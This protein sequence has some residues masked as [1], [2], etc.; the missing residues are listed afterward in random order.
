MG[1]ILPCL[2][3]SLRCCKLVKIPQNEEQ[4]T[5]WS[6]SISQESFVWAQLTLKPQNVKPLATL[7]N[8]GNM[9]YYAY[10]C[11]CHTYDAQEVSNFLLWLHP[12]GG[13]AIWQQPQVGG[14][15]GCGPPV[16]LTGQRNRQGDSPVLSIL[17]TYV[18]Q[19]TMHS[20]MPDASRTPCRVSSS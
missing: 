12:E 17:P 18:L 5:E 13:H 16:V 6:T 3:D 15:G 8:P 10:L 4:L 11:W 20:N 14:K 9:D 19:S 1:M 2:E 7:L